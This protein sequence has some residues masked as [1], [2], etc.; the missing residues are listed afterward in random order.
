M[1]KAEQTRLFII[2]KTAPIFNAKGYAGTS[3]QD[4]TAATGLTKGSIYGNFSNKDEVAVEA[5]AYNVKQLQDAFNQEIETKKNY[6]E[7]L[8]VFPSRYEKMFESQLMEKGG[9][10]ILNTAIDSDDTHPELRVK[11]FQAVISWKKTIESLLVKGMEA[12]EFRK[13][14]DN[15]ESIALTLIATIEGAVMISKLSGKE[16]HIKTIMQSVKKTI[17]ELS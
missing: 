6:R 11:A 13:D 17:E 14:I 3:L 9:C 7:K 16:A 15:P 10:P 5:F 2:E 12:G 1:G 8:L 4:I